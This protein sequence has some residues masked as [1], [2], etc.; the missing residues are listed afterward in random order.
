VKIEITGIEACCEALKRAPRAAMPAAL[1]KGLT[2][3]GKVIQDAIAVRTPIDTGEMKADLKTKITLDAE[4]RGGVAEVGFTKQAY[5]A[6]FVEYGHRMI[7]HKPA[8]K[9]LGK[10]EAHPFMRPAAEVSKEAAVEAFVEAVMTE[11]EGAGIVD[12]E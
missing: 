6:N 4:F 2:A 1:L 3:G 7:G 8:K 5:K 12:A 10:V 9:D 11:L